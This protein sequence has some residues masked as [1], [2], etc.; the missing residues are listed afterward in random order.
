MP[1]ESTVEMPSISALIACACRP[2]G[3]TGRPT[4]TAITALVTLGVEVVQSISARQAA[5]DWYA[6]GT[7]YDIVG[8]RVCFRLD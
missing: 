6:P 2:F 8:F 1:A 7:R 5:R 4:S 3:L